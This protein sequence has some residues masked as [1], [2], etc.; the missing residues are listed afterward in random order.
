MSRTETRV[1]DNNERKPK[2]GLSRGLWKDRSPETTQD[3]PKPH[4][5]LGVIFKKASTTREKEV[6]EKHG[7][8]KEET[9]RSLWELR[10]EIEE[11]K[12]G[13]WDVSS[14]NYYNAQNESNNCWPTACSI[15]AS[16]LTGMNAEELEKKFTSDRPGWMSWDSPQHWLGQLGLGVRQTG[17]L[18]PSQIHNEI[19][20]G[21][22]VV[23]S[24]WPRSWLTS[25]GHIIA[26]V[27]SRKTADWYWFVN[28]DPN[29]NNI[30]QWHDFIDDERL[31]WGGAKQY[32]IVSKG[33]NRNIA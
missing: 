33:G 12:K 3:Q 18:S 23:T 28:A 9:R 5:K 11:K 8:V 20:N 1:Q 26:L 29:Y 6:A 24:V 19:N 15:A 16:K 27:W 30:L 32:W 4:E 21:N 13:M 2:N 7:E 31:Q 17:S 10:G 22:V 25:W 14:R